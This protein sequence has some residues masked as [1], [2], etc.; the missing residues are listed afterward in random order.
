MGDKMKICPKCNTG[1]NNNSINCKDCG[2]KLSGKCIVD[3]SKIIDEFN[4][5]DERYQNRSRIL[6]RVSLVIISITYLVLY[7]LSI[8][9]GEFFALTFMAVICPTIG[10]LNIFHPKVLFILGHIFTIENPDDIELTDFYLFTSKIS[11]IIIILVGLVLMG[12]MALS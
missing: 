1:N 6:R 7:I 8:P 9:K 2:M 11:G 10:Y 12:V 3:E 5:K 4:L